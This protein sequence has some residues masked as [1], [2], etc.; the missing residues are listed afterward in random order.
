MI[1]KW[2]KVPV[3]QAEVP[4]WVFDATATRHNFASVK[5]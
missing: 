2:V 4:I 3:N 5:K 1:P